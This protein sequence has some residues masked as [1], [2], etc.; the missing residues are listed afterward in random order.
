VPTSKGKGK[1]REIGRGR[2]K[3]GV[4]GGKGGWGGERGPPVF[5]LQI[6][7]CTQT[8]MHPLKSKK[9]NKTKNTC[10]VTL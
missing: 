6:G 2:E 4:R 5:I 9:R 8:Q 3:A 10:D 7:H 1:G